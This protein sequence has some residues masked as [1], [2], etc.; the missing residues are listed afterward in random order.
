MLTT[1]IEHLLCFSNAANQGPDQPPP[2]KNERKGI[3]RNRLRRGT[4]QNIGSISFQ[5]VEMRIQIM[6]AEIVS[7]TKSNLRANRVKVPSCEVAA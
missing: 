1:E 4:N 6:G 2:P 7:I 3:N 5:K